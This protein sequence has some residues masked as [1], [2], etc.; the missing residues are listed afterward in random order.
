MTSAEAL[1]RLLKSY[2]QYYNIKTE[3]VLPP[4]SAEAEFHSCEKGYFLTKK[5]EISEAESNEYIFFFTAQHLSAQDVQR[6]GDAAWLEGLARVE[7]HKD[8][9]SSDIAVVFLAESIDDEAFKAVKKD[10]RYKSYRHTFHGWSHYRAIAF[11]TTTGRIAHNRM[12]SHMKK[13][14]GIMSDELKEN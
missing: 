2:V 7:P 11:E 12:G 10:K 9:K 5:A 3:N 14:F 8:H 4:F 6:S 13:L 1:E